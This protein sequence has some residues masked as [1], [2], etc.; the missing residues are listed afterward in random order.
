MP[1]NKHKPPQSSSSPILSIGWLERQFEAI[2]RS[3]VLINKKLDDLHQEHLLIL[4]KLGDK[5]AD[6]SPELES[7]LKKSSTLSVAIDKKVPDK[8]VPPIP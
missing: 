6:I 8:T 2:N 5:K 3:L 4:S 1:K 7:A